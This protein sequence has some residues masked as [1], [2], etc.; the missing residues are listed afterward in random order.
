MQKVILSGADLGGQEVDWVDD[1]TG[2]MIIEGH[3]YRLDP[4]EKTAHFVGYV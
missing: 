2:H 3:K 4:D 1:G